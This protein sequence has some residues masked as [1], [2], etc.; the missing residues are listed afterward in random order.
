MT[1]RVIRSEAIFFTCA[2]IIVLAIVALFSF[3]GFQGLSTFRFNDPL[4]FFFG[5]TWD[6]N[7]RIFGVIPL[8]YGSVVTTVISLLISAPIAFATAIYLTE[9]APEGV[10]E[11][12]RVVIDMFAALPSVIFGLIGLTVLVPWMRTTFDAPLGQGILPAALILVLMV[13]PTMISIASDTLRSIPNT[14]REGADALGATRMQMILK[15]LLPA[16][17]S[18]LLTAL[19]L[20]IGRAIG[21]TMAVQMVIGNITQRIPPDLVTGAATMPSTI[22]TQLPEAAL[23]EQ[24]TALIMVAFLLLCITLSLIVLVRRISS[25][26]TGG[27]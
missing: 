27:R 19:I 23:P 22:V 14:L 1:Q 5:T 24:R 7:A 13:Q 3:L 25:R 17:S 8:V 4:Q 26:A 2:A 9:V 15:V 20:G 10:R 6:K 21:E 18:G 16:A 12:L 11:P